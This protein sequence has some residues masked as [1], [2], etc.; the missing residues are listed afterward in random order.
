MPRDNTYQ[1]KTKAPL[2]GLVLIGGPHDTWGQVIKIQES[3]YH[4]IRGFG[5]S[6]TPPDEFDRYEAYKA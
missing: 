5:K 2:G 6:K 4:L 3:G 1:L